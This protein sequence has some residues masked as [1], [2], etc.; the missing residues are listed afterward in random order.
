MVAGNFQR[1]DDG[2]ALPAAYGGT[3]AVKIAKVEYTDISVKTLF[4]LPAGAIPLWWVVDIVTDFDAGTDNNLDLGYGSDGDYFANDLAIGTA[5][6]YPPATS[7]AVNG[8]L[9][10][11]LGLAGDNIITALYAPSGTAATQGAANV[12]MFYMLDNEDYVID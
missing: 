3:I 9:G 5:G 7:G 1:D 11:Q 8:R 4:S 2:F 12:I 10:V 6:I